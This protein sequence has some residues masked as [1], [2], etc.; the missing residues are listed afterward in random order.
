MELWSQAAALGSSMAH[1]H[2]GTNYHREGDLTKA[3]FHY[4]AAAMAGNEMARFNLGC[5]DYELGNR[6]RA[7]KN[8]M[9]VRVRV[10]VNDK[11]GF[12]K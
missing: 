12:G 5:M 9:R 1:F 8:W 3:K 7:V 2:L 10:R 11:R 6:E 4:E